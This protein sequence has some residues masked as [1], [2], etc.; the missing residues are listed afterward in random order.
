MHFLWQGLVLNNPQQPFLVPQLEFYIKTLVV[1]NS[2]ILTQKQHFSKKI[3]LTKARTGPISTLSQVLIVQFINGRV[4]Q[5]S[6]GS[7]KR[8][9]RRHKCHL[10]W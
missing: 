5:K 4:E 6:R 8:F 10:A 3:M 9:S 2:P 1:R 7:F